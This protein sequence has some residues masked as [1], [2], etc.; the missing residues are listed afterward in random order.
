MLKVERG[1]EPGCSESDGGSCDSIQAV[2]ES[3]LVVFVVEVE[4]V[5]VKVMV[6]LM[7]KL[8]IEVK[9]PGAQWWW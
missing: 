1:R 8:K 3:R 2:V 4:V 9:A 7:V 6:A 5:V